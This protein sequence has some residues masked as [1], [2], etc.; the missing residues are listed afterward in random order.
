ML[1]PSEDPFWNVR[2]RELDEERRLQADIDSVEASI[3]LAKKS[4]AIRNAPGFE[5]FLKAIKGLHSSSL[6]DLVTDAKL[7]DQGLR[8]QRGRVR[9]LEDVISL[10]TKSSM[11]E[12][13]ET[14]L[15]ARK[16]LLEDVLKRRPKPKQE[17]T[18]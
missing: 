14:H 11:L 1:A 16:S 10:L 3:V 17:A 4:V 8:E 7:T 6:V 15:A 9:A 12:M 13:L 18:T 2:A 5:D